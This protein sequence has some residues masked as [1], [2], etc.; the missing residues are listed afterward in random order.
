MCT[1]QYNPHNEI[2][3]W[4]YVYRNIITRRQTNE[5]V[6]SQ[7]C[8]LVRHSHFL[9]I[10]LRKSDGIVDTGLLLFFIDSQLF[11]TFWI[12]ERANKRN[13]Y[14]IGPEAA[15]D[16]E[17]WNDERRWN[18]NSLCSRVSCHLSPPASGSLNFT[19]RYTSLPRMVYCSFS[20][21]AALLSVVPFIF[22]SSDNEH[23]AIQLM[24]CSRHLRTK[25]LLGMYTIC[26]Y[27]L[28]KSTVYYFYPFQ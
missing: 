4:R 1:I 15:G 23:D 12:R 7:K 11:Q 18:A 26:R 14:G 6:I 20:D 21:N 2:A 13:R 16:K 9:K 8:T 5:Q 24:H 25:L 27:K 10:I 3:I 22:F 28:E 17:K 19:S